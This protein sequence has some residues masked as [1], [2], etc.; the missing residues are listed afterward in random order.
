[1]KD[2][3]VYLST[4]NEMF[5]TASEQS[6]AMGLITEH[7]DKDGTF[8]AKSPSVEASKHC[9]SLTKKQIFFN[10]LLFIEKLQVVMVCELKES[11]AYQKRKGGQIAD[12]DIRKSYLETMIMDQL[13]HYR[14][15]YSYQQGNCN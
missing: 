8:F 11:C 13:D 15:K 6:V 1:M 4:E 7:G 10:Y 2:K 14:Q 12:S 3:W 9:T 5:E